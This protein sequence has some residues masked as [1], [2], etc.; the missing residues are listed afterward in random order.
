[1]HKIE[2]ATIS[3]S[4]EKD[5]VNVISLHAIDPDLDKHLRVTLMGR[6]EVLCDDLG[7]ACIDHIFYDR[8]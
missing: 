3:V 1:V 5:I 4:R 6:D 7:K 8:Y 2:N